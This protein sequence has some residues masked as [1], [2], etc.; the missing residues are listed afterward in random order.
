MDFVS[1]HLAFKPLQLIF[2][3]VF[4]KVV[5]MPLVPICILTTKYCLSQCLSYSKAESAEKNQ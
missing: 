2:I 5:L 1:G 4:C 3:H